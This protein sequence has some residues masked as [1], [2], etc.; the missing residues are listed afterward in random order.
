MGKGRKN[1]FSEAQRWAIWTA[2][3][4]K[5]FKCSK[6]LDFDKCEIA[7]VIPDSVSKIVLGSLVKDYELGSDFTVNSM[8]NLLPA[9]RPC[10][11]G[12]A[13]AMQGKS[14]SMESW[15]KLI[16][17]KIPLVEGKIRSI[18]GVSESLLKTLVE[19]LER[20]SISPED[21][22][23]VLK[24]FLESVEGKP[25]GTVELR[26]SESVR[27]FLSESGLRMQPVSEIRYQKFVEGMVEGGDWKRKSPDQVRDGERFGEGR[28]R[29]PAG[30][31]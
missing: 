26:L 24:P 3:G 20:G 16:R 12:K 10:S 23:K 25:K 15:F 14:S 5:C 22:E 17:T 9:C 13:N 27:C 1:Q 21:V 7:R 11:K 30:G 8:G 4:M 19:K 6:P 2:Y 18:D 28:P 31:A 29:R